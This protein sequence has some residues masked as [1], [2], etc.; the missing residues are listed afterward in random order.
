[1]EILESDNCRLCFSNDYEL[2]D[3]F[4]EKGIELDIA[5]IL[6]K[7]FWFEVCPRI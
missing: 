5:V 1:M 3:I 7:H 2:V 4:S 6:Q